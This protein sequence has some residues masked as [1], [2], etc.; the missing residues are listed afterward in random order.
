ML[1]LISALDKPPVRVAAFPSLKDWALSK[2]R[3]ADSNKSTWKI[4]EPLCFVLFSH[5]FFPFILS[6]LAMK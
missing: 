6:F 4:S 2:A 5:S 3:E 1:P